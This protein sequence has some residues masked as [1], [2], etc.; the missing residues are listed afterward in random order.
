MERGY[1]RNA[2]ETRVRLLAAAQAA[3]AQQGYSSTGIREIAARAGVNSALLAR[4]FGSK[5]ALFEAALVQSINL[6]GLTAAPRGVFGQVLADHLLEEPA[7][8]RGLAFAVATNDLSS[9]QIVA[10]VTEQHAIEPLAAWLGAPDARARALRIVMLASAVCLLARQR[11]L[12]QG[13]AAD[14]TGTRGWFARTVQDVVDQ[15]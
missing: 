6:A 9:A 1:K 14:L 11:T 10:R 2:E 3:F 7:G 15:Q 5:A 4:Y 13:K 8:P 12:M